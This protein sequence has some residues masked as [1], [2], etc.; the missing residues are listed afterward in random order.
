MAPTS[1][2]AFLKQLRWSQEE[3]DILVEM[4]NNQLALEAQDASMMISWNQHWKRVSSRLKERGYSRSFTACRGIWKRSVE[5]QQAVRI[6]VVCFPQLL[7]SLKF[8]PLSVMF[9]N[10]WHFLIWRN[11][12]AL[13]TALIWTLLIHR[14][15]RLER[16][17]VRIGMIRS[18]RFWF[19]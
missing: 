14:R 7:L 16:L 12:F 3:I 4:T 2:M 9:S 18:M 6:M 15:H 1:E 13:E 11:S 10:F 8:I 17:L 19:L 5:A